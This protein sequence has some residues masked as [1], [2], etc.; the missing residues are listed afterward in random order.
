MKLG[1]NLNFKDLY[2]I[3][4]ISKIDQI[5][6]SY[7]EEMDK[8][9]AEGFK[10]F[11]TNIDNVGNLE[12]SNLII[13]YSPHL[14]RF[15]AKLFDIEEE[16]SATLP[17]YRNFD[18]IYKCKR[19]FV[20][21]IAIKK[22]SKEQAAQFDINLLT[23][24][25]QNIF[26]QEI[27][28]LSFAKNISDWELDTELNRDKLDIAA[29]FAAY[30]V[31]FAKDKSLLFT[32]PKK[33]EFPNLLD[34]VCS[35]ENNRNNISAKDSDI[36]Q[37]NSF[38]YTG[39]KIS[40]N[41]ALDQANYCIYCHKQDK[42]SCSKGLKEKLNEQVATATP[43]LKTIN[44]KKN[45]GGVTLSGCPLE[46]KISEMNFLKSQG[47]SLAALAVITIDNPMV[48]ATGHRIC[49]D[50]MKSCIYQKQEPVNIPKVESRILEDVLALPYGFEIY[51]LLTRWNPFKIKDVAPK[52]LTDYK[53]LIAGL[54]PAGFTLAHYLL[55]E[56]HIVC[57]IDGLKLE[58]LA[59]ELICKTNPKPIKYVK[60]L[61]EEL[62]QRKSYGFGGVAE[63]G[64]TVRFDKNYLTLAR[65]LLE[66]R[67]NFEIMGGVRLGSNITINQAFELG[68]DHVALCL[69]AGKP[70]I[71]MIPNILAKGV[72]TAS[73]FLMSLQL[74]GAGR[75]DS[76]ASLTVRMPVCIIGGGL[77]AIDTATEAL[78]Y[79]PVQVEKFL[80]RYE[81]LVND[82]GQQAVEFSWSEEERNIAY[83]FI[84][85]AK[86]IRNEMQIAAQE[87]REPNILKLLNK[88]GGVTIYYRKSLQESPAYRL[89][90]EEI[91]YALK[92]G[93][94]IS[95][96]AIPLEI[97][98]D[99]FSYAEKLVLKTGGGGPNDVTAS[100][101][102]DERGSPGIKQSLMYNDFFKL[103][104]HVA[105]A[106][107][108]DEEVYAATKN[109]K[110]I[111]GG[112]LQEVPAK[113]IL[114]AT[115]TQPNIKISDEEGHHLK[116]D[117]GYFV[118]NLDKERSGLP[119]GVNKKFAQEE[120]IT[121]IGDKG[122][123]SYFGDLHPTFAG[124]IVKAMASAKNGYPRITATISKRSPNT[125]DQ[126]FINNF[127]E[128]LDS[129]IY[130]INRLTPN[131]I[132]IIVKSPLAAKNFKP[133]QFYRLQSLESDA[134]VAEYK[135]LKTTLATEPLALTGAW[136]D[137][138][139]GLI[140]TIVLEMG[141]SSKL[142]KNFKEGQKLV[143]MGPTGAPTE[144]KNNET[145]LLAGGGLGNAV[146]FSIG[147]ALRSQGSKVIYFAAYR[148]AED[149]FKL[150]EIHEAADIVIWCCEEELLDKFRDS[151]FN[152]KGNIVQA[153]EAY[154]TGKLGSVNIELAQ[155]ERI[156][157]I[158]SHR[159]MEA[160]AKARKT[161]LL[162]YLSKPHQAIA[163]INSPMQCMMKEI[164][165]QCLQKH[166]DP[167]T[168]NE[169][170]VF[171]CTNQDQDMDSVSFEH[172]N[173]RLGQNSLQEKLTGLLVDR[174]LSK[175]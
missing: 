93:I 145:V 38:K 135:G 18:L 20:Q 98:L 168:G 105:I 96:N 166:I 101:A 106:S 52:E 110:K 5:F 162:S 137:K 149:R 58:P 157:A 46:Q 97:K 117:N 65:I 102:L 151:D 94:K 129:T 72:R 152:F 16:I 126:G 161:I 62:D 64:I 85:H 3:E 23:Q 24:T 111:G 53:I 40:L 49:N 59:E 172:L 142:C 63:Y 148:K 164:C 154:A 32:L 89:N 86:A 12:Y 45:E 39:G 153:M 136:V 56:G 50:C 115:G 124:N 131:I 66:R 35:A 99:K 33:I 51:S 132:E 25:L 167:V 116:I 21:R 14:E 95:T 118:P 15:L 60:E 2:T 42:D 87:A 82:L 77:T 36:V 144:L 22:Y 44:Y 174:V 74:T 70:N 120:F 108:D 34:W 48:V 155:V 80:K 173:S 163:S 146:L 83:E 165:A 8:A 150:E 27:T 159:M 13:T 30:I 156:I 113:T 81:K 54:G 55:N 133:G 138:E 90:H 9:L 140:S 160:I 84:S 114:I 47:H 26:T 171:S 41:E 169:Y 119:Q 147:K 175:G 11:K 71:P 123:I 128:L 141:A 69:G 6:I 104:R 78:A 68:F 109:Y 79:Y 31:Y 67:Q 107:R 125:I 61:W 57:A 127:K 100:E 4:G 76:L 19:Q 88:W 143:L 10:N 112:R 17:A 29:R 170:Y 130:K 43:N 122:S 73:D 37:R 7:L 92:E 1:F 139:A 103:D 121:T 75:E 158:G 134:E 28:D 91:E